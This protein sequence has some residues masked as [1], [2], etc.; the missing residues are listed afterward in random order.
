[1]KE[2]LESDMYK[3]ISRILTLCKKYKYGV[4][5]SLP[6]DFWKKEDT[7]EE[8]LKKFKVLK[9]DYKYYKKQV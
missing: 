6:R 7:I 1:M 4:N 2:K 9:E 3:I 8:L 5:N